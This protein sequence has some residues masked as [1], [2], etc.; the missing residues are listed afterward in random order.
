[1]LS[2]GSTKFKQNN[3]SWLQRTNNW[4]M[5]LKLF[6]VL[7]FHVPFRLLHDVPS[8]VSLSE[9]SCFRA[10]KCLSFIFF[11]KTGFIHLF[12]ICKEMKIRP[13]KKKNRTISHTL[14]ILSLL[15]WATPLLTLTIHPTARFRARWTS[16]RA[17]TVA[18]WGMERVTLTL[19]IVCSPLC[20]PWT[21]TSLSATGWE[22]KLCYW[23]L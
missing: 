18:I 22:E 19:K 21:G 13:K 15:H 5:G 8:S 20:F 7:C 10:A 4:M 16:S 12:P 11:C 23:T 17:G 1:M 9:L 6:A 3:L 2:S 14:E